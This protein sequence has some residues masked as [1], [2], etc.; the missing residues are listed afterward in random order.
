MAT[1]TNVTYTVKFSVPENPL[2]GAITGG[3]SSIQ[4]ELWEILCFIA[5]IGCHGNRGWFRASLN[6]TIKLADPENPR[7]GANSLYVS[8]SV[9]KL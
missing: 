1:E 3:V 2:V 6:D 4:A 8:S 5:T 9:P 7:F